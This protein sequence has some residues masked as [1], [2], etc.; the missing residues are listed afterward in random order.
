MIW[1]VA[2][3][4]ESGAGRLTLGFSTPSTCTRCA[5]GDGCGAGLFS[6]LLMRSL[7]RVELPADLQ[8][9]VGESVRVG[10]LPSRLAAAAAIHYGLPLLAFLAGASL[11]HGLSA[12]VVAQDVA[13]LAGGLAAFALSVPFIQRYVPVSVNP[14][15]ERLSCTTGDTT[16]CNS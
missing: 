9:Q 4:L 5:R 16:S 6:A 7:T 13:A 12:G 14:R 15:I 8:A 10:V 1:Q 3:V 2:R 11:G